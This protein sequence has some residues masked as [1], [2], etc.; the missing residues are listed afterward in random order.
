MARVDDPSTG[1]VRPTGPIPAGRA[2]GAA[3]GDA[4]V[5]PGRADW[6]SYT[7]AD[8]ARLAAEDRRFYQEAI[9]RV[10][11]ARA[12]GR[13]PGALT[14]QAQRP[15]RNL[16]VRPQNQFDGDA[17]N[18]CG[19][20]SL[21]SILDFW[22]PGS[23]IA[24]HQVLDKAIRQ[25]DLFT[26]PDELLRFA[27]DNGYRAGIKTDASL[28]DI[29]RMLDQGV[30]VQVMVD[31]DGDGGDITLHYVAVTGYK[32]DASG[33]LTGL[34]ITDP[35][36]G[37]V[38]EE[39]ADH[40]TKRW[41]NLKLQGVETGLN[42]MM[43][44]YVPEGDR[45]IKG[46]DGQVRRA[47]DLEL[48]G[49]G[50]LGSVFSDSQPA[51]TLTRGI[52]NAVNGAQNRNPVRMLGGA[53]QVLAGLPGLVGGA[54][55]QYVQQGGDAALAW[56]GRKWQVGGPAGKAAAI[57]GYAGG[58]IA[59]GIGW[60]LSKVGAAESWVVGQFGDGVGRAGDALNS[61]AGAAW[62]GLGKAFSG[63]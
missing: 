44:T 54:A 63:W 32:T 55:G 46:L 35:G 11:G 5:K 16:G 10:R 29:R 61:A 30:P 17:R 26:A 8:H 39:D 2:P 34:T 41:S 62:R 56:A 9:R 53:F 33:R 40:F 57:L 1:G 15:A 3:A 21:A 50:F 27:R 14:D 52:S 49:N 37:E 28:D 47:A 48:P 24:K 19:T 4:P 31:P 45:P 20:T 51:R 13:D 23:P 58:G 36:G 59:K 18:A 42:R 7:R 38:Y 43:M 6:Y 12:A 25:A 60:G 22:A